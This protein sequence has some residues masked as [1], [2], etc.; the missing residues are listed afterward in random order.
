MDDERR[1]IRNEKQRRRR[2][3]A[4]ACKRLPLELE[5]EVFSYMKTPRNGRI[6]VSMKWQQHPAAKIIS[7]IR[8]DILHAKISAFQ[9]LYGGPV[10]FAI[11][12]QKTT[13]LGIALHEIP[14]GRAPLG[15]NISDII[16]SAVTLACNHGLRH[17][18]SEEFLRKL[19]KLL[20]N[21]FQLR[22]KRNIA[23]R[24]IPTIK[25]AIKKETERV[26]GWIGERAY[27][28]QLAITYLVFFG[29]LD[30]VPHD[31]VLDGHGQLNPLDDEEDE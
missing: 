18:T 12:E 16:V 27:V 23:F 26:R 1:A 2:A 8:S 7:S 30:Y 6:D 29:N 11:H 19:S 21:N 13:G 28:R 25:A 20:K 24:C 15:T 17:Y 5:R 22:F 14:T 9:S 10:S 31:Q 4:F 3:L